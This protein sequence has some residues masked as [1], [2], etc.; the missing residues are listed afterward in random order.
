MY[1]EAPSST[2]SDSNSLEKVTDI[3][4][5]SPLP[6]HQFL[7]ASMTFPGPAAKRIRKLISHV[8]QIAS[9]CGGGE[10]GQYRRFQR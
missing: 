1:A 6:A 3:W 7:C 4:L 9:V 5:G 2:H 10:R 8:Q